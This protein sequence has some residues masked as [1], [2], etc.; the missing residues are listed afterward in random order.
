M[1]T[2]IT[3][4]L[5]GVILICLSA[6]YL[7]SRHRYGYW[8]KRGVP[9][10][11]EPVLFFGNLPFLM[12]KSF[13]DAV[14]EWTKKY[15]NDYFGM[16]F[17]WTPALVV[18]SQELAKHVLVKD[19]DS[20]QNRFSYSGLDDDPLGSLNLF[21]V[22]NP[23]WGQMRTDISPMF[24][25]ARLKGFA[26]LMN[27]NSTE[28]VKRVQTD[29]ID[30]KEPV[31]FKKLF[32]MYTS[33]T[34]A[35]TVFG[36][37]VSVLKEGMSPLWSITCNMLKWTFW[38]GLEFTL[39]FFVPVVAA[40]FKFKFFSK[41]A[42]DYVKKLFW[43]VVEERKRT[44][45]TNDTDLVNL[46][47][48]LK[49]NLKLPAE[50]GTD[51]ADNLMLA[52]AA[53]FILGSIETSSTTLSYCIHELSHHPEEQEKLYREVSKAL[54]ASG[55]DILDYNDLLEIKYLTACIHGTYVC[56]IYTHTYIVFSSHIANQLPTIH[57]FVTTVYER[58]SID[59][60][61]FFIQPPQ[62][63]HELIL[64]K[65]VPVVEARRRITR[66]KAVSFYNCNILTL[67][68][69]IIPLPLSELL[70]GVC[71]M[72]SSFSRSWRHLANNTLCSR[73]FCDPLLSAN[74]VHSYFN[75][76]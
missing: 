21:S 47:L 7:F 33:D 16:Y 5:L 61:L 35:Y 40:I 4:L 69:I 70:F 64:P 15:K 74:H 52:Q 9:Q 67:I 65:I 28:L 22:K 27:T 73:I 51:L 6:F 76:W 44:G 57:A 34:V 54:E 32:L 10:V 19:F 49:A 58:I 55:K 42:T 59:F 11:E 26:N 60:L 23:I 72:S 41:E 12:R 63:L 45:L 18:N 56:G 75:T 68:I 43:D 62:I 3:Q 48:K 1:L 31:D 71:Y 53:V 8:K 38:R 66:Y 36:I 17:G 50:S 46:L 39:I 30:N 2:A 37:R 14:S 29:F 24:T 13:F 25:S 20:F